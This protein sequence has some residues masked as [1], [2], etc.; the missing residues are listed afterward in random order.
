M[1]LCKLR[2]SRTNNVNEHWFSKIGGYATNPSAMSKNSLLPTSVSSLCLSENG[3]YQIKL[4]VL[5]ALCC[6]N[7]GHA[8]LARYSKVSS[9]AICKLG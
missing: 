2:Y 5:I 6:Q 1:L 3:N 9:K 7:A 8:L 4:A